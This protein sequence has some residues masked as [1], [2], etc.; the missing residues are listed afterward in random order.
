MCVRATAESES[1]DPSELVARL[2][3]GV[4][5][6]VAARDGGLGATRRTGPLHARYP[7]QLLLG[8]GGLGEPQRTDGGG[9]PFK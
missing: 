9:A 1:A 4:A 3:L 8:C 2:M 6:W 5:W 7:N